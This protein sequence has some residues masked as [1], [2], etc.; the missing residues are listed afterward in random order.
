MVPHPTAPGSKI[1]TSWKMDRAECDGCF[2]FL[3]YFQRCFDL[4]AF[5]LQDSEL[6]TSINVLNE[7]NFPP[8]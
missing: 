6:F 8:K 3:V 1:A 4:V 7:M 5:I 2:A